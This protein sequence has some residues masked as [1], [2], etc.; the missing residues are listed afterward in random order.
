ITHGTE[1]VYDALSQKEAYLLNLTGNNVLLYQ[2]NNI[3]E[4]KAFELLITYEVYKNGEK[5]K[6]EVIAGIEQDNLKEFKIKDTTLGLNIQDDQ[7][8][9][10]IGY[11]GNFISGDF[12]LEEDLTKYMK[13][14]FTNTAKLTLGSDIYLYYA[15]TDSSISTNIPLGV[16]MDSTMTNKLVKSNK[17]IVLIKLSFNER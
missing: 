7:I 10:L 2:L 4:N 15:T 1:L 9:T 13:T 17:N 11:N 16:S 3:P 6:E 8:S 14:H 12:K 5:V